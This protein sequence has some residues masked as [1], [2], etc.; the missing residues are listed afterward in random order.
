M[1]EFIRTWLWKIIPYDNGKIDADDTGTSRG[2][3]TVYNNS[4][5][6]EI[7]YIHVAGSYCGNV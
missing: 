3:N 5:I 4:S 7:G 1:D 6:E 2:G